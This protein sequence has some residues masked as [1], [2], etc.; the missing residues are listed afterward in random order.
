MEHH[1]IIQVHP[2]NDIPQDDNFPLTIFHQPLKNLVIIVSTFWSSQV[3]QKMCQLL[4]KTEKSPAFRESQDDKH[5]TFKGNAYRQSCG[6]EGLR[7]RCKSEDILVRNFNRFQIKQ[8]KKED[9]QAKKYQRC[10]NT[11]PG[12][13]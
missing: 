13:T 2:N 7:F 4:V 3:D 1:K 6:S 9:K 11:G 12:K 8:P 5:H 10:G